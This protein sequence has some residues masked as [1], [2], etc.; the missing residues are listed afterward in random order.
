MSRQK[1]Q[2][3]YW[4]TKTNKTTWNK[5]GATVGLIPFRKGREMRVR[6]I[7]LYLA[8]PWYFSTEG[9]VRERL[10]STGGAPALTAPFCVAEKTKS[11]YKS[12]L[13]TNEQDDRKH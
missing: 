1:G 7:R 5:P 11:A 9:C 2:G 13:Y 12:A 4:N 8:T 6:G 3:Y 10:P